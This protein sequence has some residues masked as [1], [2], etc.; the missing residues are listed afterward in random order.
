MTFFLADYPSNTSDY[1]NWIYDSFHGNRPKQ[2]AVFDM[3]ID[4]FFP[5][6]Q[7]ERSYNNQ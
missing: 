3:F 6:H 2:N 4:K 5:E 1:L 7:K